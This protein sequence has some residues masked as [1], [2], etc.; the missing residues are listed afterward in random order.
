MVNTSF[1]QAIVGIHF[2]KHQSSIPLEDITAICRPVRNAVPYSH[3]SLTV[4]TTAWFCHFL[5][6][7]SEI[8]DK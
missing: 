5:A 1:Q 6:P 7:E 3:H 8:N 2:P 4:P